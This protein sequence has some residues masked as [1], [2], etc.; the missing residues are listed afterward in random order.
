MNTNQDAAPARKRIYVVGAVLERDGLI[1]AA[2]RSESMSLPGMW[3]FPGGKIE[4]GETAEQALQR[5]LSEE[6]RCLA[7]VG[8]H[9]ETTEHDYDFGTV[10]L[11][12]YYCTLAQGEPAL[13]EHSAIEWLSLAELLNLDW[14]PADVP[15]V[16]KIIQDRAHHAR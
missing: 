10:I 16:Q 6:L 8:A 2:Q 1:L 14:A 7:E 13:T 12:T 15:A 4:V 5:E 11:S 9:V 3:E